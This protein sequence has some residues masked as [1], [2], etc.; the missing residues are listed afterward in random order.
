V[1]VVE[2]TAYL[3]STLTTLVLS[4]TGRPPLLPVLTPRACVGLHSSIASP[5]LVDEVAPLGMLTG[6]ARPVR[7]AYH[8]AGEIA[9]GVVAVSLLSKP[10]VEALSH[11]P[12][13]S[14]PSLTRALPRPAGRSQRVQ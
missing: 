8:V 10:T 1:S 6:T 14:R 9:Y 3:N 7:V 12:H 11:C 4:S 13:L 2:A 5:D